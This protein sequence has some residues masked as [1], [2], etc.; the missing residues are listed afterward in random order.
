MIVIYTD[1]YSRS[2]VVQL[3]NR[4]QAMIIVYINGKGQDILLFLV[5]QE[6]NYLANW[7]IDSGLLSNQIIK[8]I[9]N[10]QTNNEIGLE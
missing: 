10:R 1:Q 7:Y 2:K 9:N 6:K 3:D 5:I 4:E 8:P